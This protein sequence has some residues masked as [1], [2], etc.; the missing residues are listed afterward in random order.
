MNARPGGRRIASAAAALVA[1]CG[2]QLA[3][4][5]RALAAAPAATVAVSSHDFIV[6]SSLDGTSLEARYIRPMAAGTYP[7]VFF[8]HGGGGNVSSEAPRATA[9]AQQGFVGVTWSARGHGNSGGLFDF[10]GAKTVQDSRDV[11]DWVFSHKVLTAADPQRAAMTGYS[12]GG[13]TTNLVGAADPRL[14]VLAPGH[15]F[16]GL[17]E[18]LKPNGCIKFSVDVVILSAAYL[19]MGARTDPNLVSRWTTYLQTGAE[20]ANP[21]DGK[22]PSQEFEARSPRNYTAQLTQPSMWVQAFDDTLFP[23]D[24]AVLMYQRMPNANNHLYLSWGGHFAPNPPAYETTYRETQIQRWMGRWLRGDPNGIDT[25]PPVTYWYLDVASGQLVRQ[26]SPSWP[27]P[28]VVMSPVMLTPGQALSGAG[29]QG[30]AND[31]VAQFG[32]NASGMGQTIKALPDHTPLDTMITTTAPLTSSVL[33]AGAAHADL[34][35]LS[36]GSPSQV[37]VKVWDVA[38]DGAG[39]LLARA[40]TTPPGAAGVEQRVQ[41]DLWHDAVM[42]PAGHHFEVWV[43]PSDA[44]L[45]EPPPPAVGQVLAGSTVTLPLVGGRTLVTVAP[46]LT[47]TGSSGMPGTSRSPRLPWL[48]AAGLLAATTL[49]VL[50]RRRRA[51]P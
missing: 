35:W 46:R 47:T 24:Q 29:A 36:S 30:F 23:V 21:L 42:V 25:E 12:Q 51:F 26:M 43:Q 44:P 5:S 50:A 22:L 32:A 38:P 17:A 3:P 48:P 10:F 28:G 6:L 8:A 20:I 1:V 34:K 14:K 15:T 7:V 19:A 18:S 41:F 45:W 27:P 40:C 49:L 31:P 37:S 9:L 4:T 39:T 13:G 33:Y 16:S 2:F 11:M